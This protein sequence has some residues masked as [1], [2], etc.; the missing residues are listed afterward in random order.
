MKQFSKVI[1]EE[2]KPE[3]HID[4][5]AQSCQHNAR[6]IYRNEFHSYWQEILHG[7][8]VIFD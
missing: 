4:G 7:S 2:E 1:K 3:N 8:P 5:R 6:T